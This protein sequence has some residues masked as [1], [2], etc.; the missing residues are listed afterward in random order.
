[1]HQIAPQITKI[2]DMFIIEETI[3][4]DDSEEDIL[5]CVK[6]LKEMRRELS[7]SRMKL[8]ETINQALFNT[9]RK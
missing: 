6:R 9:L 2:E 7:Q 4:G 1:M 5:V 8:L 3:K